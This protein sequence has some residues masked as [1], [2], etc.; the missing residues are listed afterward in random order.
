MSNV[1]F[2]GSVLQNWNATN[3]E[4]VLRRQKEEKWTTKFGNYD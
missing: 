4:Q 3:N 2:I 1:I